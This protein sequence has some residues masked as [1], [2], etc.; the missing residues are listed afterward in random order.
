MSQSDDNT[1]LAMVCMDEEDLIHAKVFGFVPEDR[2]RE[3]S[4]REKVDYQKLIRQGCC[5][6]CGDEV[7]D[8]GFVEDFALNL[9]EI[10]GVEIVNLGYDKWNALSTIQKLESSDQAIECVEIAQHSSVLHSP[11]KLLKE[12]ILSGTF[13]YDENLL[14]EINFSN[15]KCTED[16]NRNKYVNK[17]KSAGK[18]DMVVA[19]INAVQLL[20]QELLHGQDFVIQ[21]I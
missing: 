7:I 14:L 4:L 19:L 17:K 11:T 8:Y 20:E 21:T 6:A 1:A 12:R 5:F 13:R 2:I 16:T 15:A 3:K 9:Q 18:V 10:Y